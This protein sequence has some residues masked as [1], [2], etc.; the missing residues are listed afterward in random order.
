MPRKSRERLSP[1]KTDMALTEPE[2]GP[3]KAD[4]GLLIPIRVDIGRLFPHVDVGQMSKQEWKHVL[5]AAVRLGADV[6]AHNRQLQVALG[7]SVS[8][9]GHKDYLA[10]SSLQA[11][12]SE[13]E[14]A[15]D[16]LAGLLYQLDGQEE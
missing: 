8:P 12:Q 6:I 14:V 7:I 10:E 3:E 5:A 4:V 13:R 11:E 16:G 9:R 2:R 1:P 15:E